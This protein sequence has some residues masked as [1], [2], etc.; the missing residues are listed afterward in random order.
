MF[1]NNL[2]RA[3]LFSIFLSMLEPFLAICKDEVQSIS[4]ICPSTAKTQYMC[5]HSSNTEDLIPFKRPR[6][7]K[8]LR[9][10]V[11]DESNPGGNTDHTLSKDMQLIEVYLGGCR[12]NRCGEHTV[13]S[14]ILPLNETW[15]RGQVHCLPRWL[16][17]TDQI[18][19]SNVIGSAS[20]EV[21]GLSIFQ[22]CKILPSFISAL[23]YQI[24]AYKQ[25]LCV[26]Q[27][28]ILLIP[29]CLRAALLSKNYKHI[30]PKKLYKTWINQ[31]AIIWE[32][33]RHALE[34]M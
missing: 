18:A 3:S 15:T 2:V 28:L 6:K 22:P 20:N 14:F 8:G 13:T 25:I 21:D 30:F 31:K 24:W 33:I 23:C 27:G 34:S 32:Q 29:L 12:V 16:L 19:D 10:C 9:L 5:T 7:H 4:L 17:N 26:Y 1:R 11:K